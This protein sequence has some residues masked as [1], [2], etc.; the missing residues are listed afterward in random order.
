MSELKG[1]GAAQTVAGS[2]WL[3]YSPWL[4]APSGG[5][6]KSP[7]QIGR[8]DNP[9]QCTAPGAYVHDHSGTHRRGRR[10]TT[11]SSRSPAPG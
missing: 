6:K 5:P 3:D 4:A 8:K 2:W 1:R 10:T 11:R 9:V 7:G